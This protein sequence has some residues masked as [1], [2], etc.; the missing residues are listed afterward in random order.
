MPEGKLVALHVLLSLHTALTLL[1]FFSGF[2]MIWRA[3]KDRADW[4]YWVFAA[5]PLG[6]EGQR[7][8]VGNRC[9][10]QDA[11]REFWQAPPGTWAPDLYGIHASIVTDVVDA[12]IASYAAGLIVSVAFFLRS[13]R[14]WFGG[15]SP[16]PM[17][18]AFSSASARD[19]PK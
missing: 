19:A 4:I 7:L 5:L 11:A 2:V 17:A 18:R 10:V 13:R 9:V 12:C 14:G 3:S 1:A 6:I 15:Q 16:K 8:L